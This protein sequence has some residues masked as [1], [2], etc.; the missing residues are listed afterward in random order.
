MMRPPQ[1]DRS[2]TGTHPWHHVRLRAQLLEAGYTDATLLSMVRAKVLTRCRQGAYVPTPLWDVATP[3]ERH[4]IRLG[5]V[6]MRSTIDA[7]GSHLSSVL[8]LG[9]EAYDVDLARV[10]TNRRDGKAA[11]SAAG[12]VQHC[13]VLDDADIVVTGGLRHTAAARALAET[14]CLPGIDTKRGLV[15]A[16]SMLHRKVLTPAEL[17]AAIEMVERWPGS[18]PARMVLRLADPR[19]ESVAES[20]LFHLCFE[21]QLPKP[22]PQFE[23]RGALGEFLGRVDFALPEHGVFIEFDG[24]V[25]YGKYIREDDDLSEVL[26]REKQREDAIREATGWVCVRVTWKDLMEPERLAAR[27]RRAIEVARRSRAVA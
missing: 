5:A 23:V 8:V 1:P 11:R 25:K 7:V 6:L 15:I 4:L 27:I 13:G 10:H 20:L 16:N 26:V 9:A 24:R 14:L 22:E 19:I 17:A 21:H 2:P 12:V 3:I 18:F